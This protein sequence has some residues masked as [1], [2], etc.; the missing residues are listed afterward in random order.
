MSKRDLL[1]ESI[2]SGISKGVFVETGTNNGLFAELV[3]SANPTNTLYMIDHCDHYYQ[4]KTKYGNRVLHAMPETI[5]FLHID[6]K[7]RAY[8]FVKR[9]IELYFPKVRENGFVMGSG[10]KDIDDDARND[11]GDVIIEG[12]PHGAVHAFSEFIVKNNLTGAGAEERIFFKKTVS[13]PDTHCQNK[14]IVFVTEFSTLG[15]SANESVKRLLSLLSFKQDLIVFV[16]ADIISRLSALG[17]N[18]TFVNAEQVADTFSEKYMKLAQEIETNSADYSVHNKINMLR[19]AKS[20]KPE[21]FLYA[22]ID[23][24]SQ[25]NTDKF[26]NCKFPTNKL[27]VF[28][29]DSSTFI[30]PNSLVEGVEL[31]YEYKLI[32]LQ[33]QWLTSETMFPEMFRDFP[34]MVNI[35]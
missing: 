6:G 30:I 31:F 21:Y 22:W 28:S 13:P 1:L 7:N 8:E 15:L 27:T 11:T 34:D 25:M 12:Q 26:H 32:E 19:H 18:I 29:S 9:T 24:S 20:I 23:C 14:K 35:I 33:S 16:G 3:L 5:D 4:M 2:I 17:S 10:A